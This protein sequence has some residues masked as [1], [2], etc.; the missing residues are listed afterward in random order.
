MIKWAVHCNDDRRVLVESEQCQIREGRLEFY[1]TVIGNRL[2]VKVFATGF[3][4]YFSKEEV[5]PVPGVPIDIE[6][7]KAQLVVDGMS[8]ENVEDLFRTYEK[9]APADNLIK[10]IGGSNWPA[11]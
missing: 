3:W 11:G 2:T 8:R 4:R 6:G 7:L 5:V 9:V 1:N 10:T